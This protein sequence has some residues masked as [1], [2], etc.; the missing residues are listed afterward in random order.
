[1]AVSHFPPPP[2]T[3]WCDFAQ[4]IFARAS[5]PRPELTPIAT[6]DYPAPARRPLNSTLDCGKILRHFAIR[7]P[8]WRVALSRVMTALERGTT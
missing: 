8:D 1:L 7:Q 4:E 3:S 2:P 6:S 5:G